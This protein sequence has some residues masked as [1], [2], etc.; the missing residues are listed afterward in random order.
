MTPTRIRARQAHTD[1][2]MNP[3][4]RRVRA[5]NS[6]RRAPFL[7]TIVLLVLASLPL[8]G[9]GAAQGGLHG[10]TLER[11]RSL[12]RQTS[13]DV[14]AARA[15]VEAA[16]GR[17]HQA[18]ALPN[19]VLAYSHEQ[20]SGA[21]G[22]NA[23]DI[24][25][26]EQRIELG[27]QRSARVSSARLHREAAEARLIVVEADLDQAVARA[28]AEAVAAERRAAL[29]EEA[30][31]QFA[32]AVGVMQNRLAA[33]DV[34][35]YAARRLGLESARYAALAAEMHLERSSA[36]VRL[37]TLTGSP[38]DTVL[39][40]AAADPALST[41]PPDSVAA[42]AVARAPELRALRL[43]AGA[44][45]AEARLARAERIPTPIASLG[46][47]NER[48]VGMDGSFS[49]FIAGVS[50]PLP[51]ADRGRGTVAAAEAETRRATAEASADARRVIR[52]A[53]TALAAAQQ[54]DAQTEALQGQLGA[55]SQAALRA[56]QA[57]YDEGEIT[58][59]EW[60]D[61]VRAYQ[62]AEAAYARLVAE[63][64]IQR[65]RLERLLGVSLIR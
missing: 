10:L 45:G 44:V 34:S 47:K 5:V 49:G 55:E 31:A 16:A 4:D 60:L 7:F 26:L 43:T 28:Y 18:R 30:A 3:C 54:A 13:P 50:I 53:A 56:A 52:E 57:A 12:A 15:A 48:A 41:I 65:A 62:E 24:A 40:G 27:G 63:S 37:A 61:A 1:M 42:W 8:P 35:G 2:P 36:L 14:T 6:G 64:I 25:V 51:I 32:R 46:Y 38:G 21:A 11:A 23:Q 22:T 9:R 17:E 19:P 33:G 20:A 58:L 29:A 59:V 39:A